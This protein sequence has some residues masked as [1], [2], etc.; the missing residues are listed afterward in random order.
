[1]D[2]SMTGNPPLWI[3]TGEASGD[4]HAAGLVNQL[5]ILSPGLEVQA[6][7]GPAL[8]AEGAVLLHHIN[9]LAV[10][11]FS[12]IVSS[13]PRIYR[14]F[15]G[16]IKRLE[17]ERPRA[18]ILVDFPDFNLRLARKTH[19]L[20]IPVIYYISPQLWAWRRG[21]IKK[22]RKY[23]DRMIVIFPFEQDFYRKNGIEAVF[24]GYPLCAKIAGLAGRDGEPLVPVDPEPRGP[25]IGILPGSRQSEVRTILPVLIQGME[26][27]QRDFPEVVFLLPQAP[28]V[29]RQLIDDL[30]SHFT[31][32]LTIVRG[33]TYDVMAQSDFIFVA[34]GTATVEATCLAVPM[35]VVYRVS[36]LSYMIARSL[37][38]VD[39]IAMP[40]L[41]AGKRLVPELV[42]SELTPQALLNQARDWIVDPARLDR[43]RAE[44]AQVRTKLQSDDA[45]KNGAQ[46]ILEYLRE[47]EV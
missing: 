17:R 42:Q 38:K 5:K 11:G 14:L 26:L 43:M 32:Q 10:M 46:A 29:P 37:V 8:E 7:G 16:L 28:T 36:G 25:V 24:T 23:V 34:S 33:R 19:A 3:V 15:R 22:I 39:H 20:G 21:R 27:I 9:E 4:L 30:V 40:N 41:V 31:G 44:L 1:M 13:L 47:R 45:Y 18:V 35:V 12:E 2:S 6:I